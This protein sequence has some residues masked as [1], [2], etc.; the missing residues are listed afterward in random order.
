[1]DESL[2]NTKSLTEF[3]HQIKFSNVLGTYTSFTVCKMDF[4]SGYL[5]PFLAFR[6]I[7]LSH[8]SLLWW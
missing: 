6:L 7:F 2:L 5:T 4:L 1:M 8:I 3:R